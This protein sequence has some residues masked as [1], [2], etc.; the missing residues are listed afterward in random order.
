MRPHSI[1]IYGQPGC[2]KANNAARL[3]Q[4][5]GLSKVYDG[6]CEPLASAKTLPRFDTLIL[7]SEPPQRCPVRSMSY[8]QAMRQI[9]Q[10]R[11][12]GVTA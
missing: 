3:Q 9:Q 5:F 7:A 12:Q 2:G 1:V 10:A 4:H 11:S 6:D 8:E